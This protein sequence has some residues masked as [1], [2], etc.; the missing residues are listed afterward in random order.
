[1]PKSHSQDSETDQTDST[2][3][4]LGCC[5]YGW[6]S[7]PCGAACVAVTKAFL[8]WAK[9]SHISAV[10]ETPSSDPT[11]PTVLATA[12]CG[13]I[14]LNCVLYGWGWN[15]KI[16]KI[17]GEPESRLWKSDGCF[18]EEMSKLLE[19]LLSGEC[20]KDLFK[21]FLLFK[22]THHFIWV[23]LPLPNSVICVYNVC[24]LVELEGLFKWR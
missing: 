6:M 16:W 8:L 10:A 20:I 13:W 3:V 15:E 5:F 22:G 23:L 7:T 12:T 9:L 21:A 14:H 11:P 1:M 2:L 24:S 18:M 17:L 4:V 19:F